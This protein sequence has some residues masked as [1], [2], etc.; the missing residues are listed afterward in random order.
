VLLSYAVITVSFALVAGYSVLGQRASARETELMR[1]GYIPLIVA[2]R[3]AVAGQNTF[4][5][6][7]NN[8]TEARNPADKRVWFETN[9]TLGRP[10]V[11]AEL[12]SALSRAF[13]S[14]D[15]EMGRLLSTEA[16]QIERFL[17]GDKEILALLFDALKQA[18]NVAAEQ[19]RDQLV[20][21]GSQ[22][23]S[24]LLELENRVNLH[25]DELML[26][27]TRRERAT[28]RVLLVWALFTVALGVGVALYARR[29]LRPL[30]QITARANDVAGGD[31]TPQDIVATND[32]IG[33]LARTFESMVA[34]IAKAN[35][36]LLD[37][38]RLATIGKMAAH[39]THEVR[40]PL[41]SIALNLELLQDELPDSAEAKALHSAIRGEVERLTDLTEQYLS[42]TRKNHPTLESENLGEVVSE[43]MAF[44]EPGLLRAG[45]KVVL[46]IADELP[47]VAIDE[48]QIRQVIHN[49]LRNARQAMP[50]GGQVTVRVAPGRGVVIVS[51][52]DQ[53]TG[54]A[55]DVRDKL[56]EPFLTSKVHGTGLGLAISKQIIE[57]HG[58][59]IRC[60]DNTPSGTRFAIELPC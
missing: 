57:A 14:Q 17:E 26:E 33:D 15:A 13:T 27:I 25:L 43:A 53:G 49:L 34:G 60:E 47:N 46:D 38:E 29:V 54:V 21:R 58:G 39:V 55:P 28:L 4:N 6:Q 30:A 48:A 40:N 59:S 20:S 19:L 9:L 2:L 22:A 8:V 50:D 32:E 23:S 18:D 45:V 41:S 16:N 44:L 3:N 7:L 36:K 51:V 35:R 10:K 52:E 56:F 37:S 42:L 5:S 12:R 31:L 11:F 24:Q 1:S